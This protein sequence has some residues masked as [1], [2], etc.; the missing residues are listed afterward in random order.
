MNQVDVVD[1]IDRVKRAL[2]SMQRHDWEQGVAA[3]AMLELG[4]IPDTIALARS[5]VMRQTNGRFATIGKWNPITDSASVG[6]AVAFAANETGDQRL[7]DG[8][9]AMLE[10]IHTTSH[11]NSDGIIYHTY[12]PGT[13]IMSDAFFML[14]PFLAAMGEHDL[15]LE[16]IEGYR[17]VLWNPPARLYSHSWD[18]QKGR[19]AREAFWG[20]GNGWAAAGL[21]RVVLHL[22]EER[23][24]DR[25]RLMG[26]AREVVEGCLAHA[27]P[28]GMFHNIVNDPESFPEVNLSQMVA[29]SIYRGVAGGWIGESFL[30]QAQVLREA[31][32]A[33]VDDQGFVQNVCGVPDFNRPYVAPEGQAFF[34]LMEAAVR[35]LKVS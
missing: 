19:F 4:H 18:G 33:Q 31:A 22:P 10:V 9:R 16:Q 14:P 25:E 1:R 35:D 20:V 23:R 21:A 7:L 30:R 28:D 5:A 8:V 32:H 15:A 26:Y 34:L 12:E 6:E 24:A 13:C 11:R 29:Y 27:R 17:R 3:Q 2:L